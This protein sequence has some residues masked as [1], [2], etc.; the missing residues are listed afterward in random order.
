MRRAIG[1]LLGIVCC[2]WGEAQAAGLELKSE[3][4]RPGTKL[5]VIDFYATWCKPCMAAVPQWKALH[6]KYRAQ[7]LRF[8]VIGAEDRGHCAKPPDWTPDRVICDSAGEWQRQFNVLRLPTSFLYSWDGAVQLRGEDVETIEAGI[9]NF[10]TQHHLA[11]EVD[12][13]NVI[14]DKFAVSTNPDWLKKYITAQLTAQSKF[15][16]VVASEER[17]PRAPVGK[18]CS[19]AFSL[20]PNSVLRITVQ[21]DDRNRRELS[22]AIE[23]NGCVLAAAHEPY[24]G[25]DLTEDLDSMRQAAG[26][27][28]KALLARLVHGEPIAW[29]EAARATE[30]LSP[31]QAKVAGRRAAALRE[32]PETPAASPVKSGRARKGGPVLD[33]A[34][35]SDDDPFWDTP[36][37]K[38]E[39]EAP[40]RRVVQEPVAR[41]REPDT[42]PANDGRYDMLDAMAANRGKSQYEIMAQA[43]SLDEMQQKSLAAQVMSTLGDIRTMQMAFRED[44]MRGQGCYAES[45]EKLH[46]VSPTLAA[47]EPFYRLSIVGDCKSFV[48]RADAKLATLTRFPHIVLSKDGAMSME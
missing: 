22:L 36:T 2:M 31:M 30:D 15:D 16:V 7:G 19:A 34:E 1:L 17:L 33:S 13:I 37:A 9:R 11:L 10:Y 24:K 21:G 42:G 39:P 38:A 48:A 46:Y 25:Q 3:L 20:P 32:E 40:P 27:A 45:L 29:P 4:A 12:E 44:P 35:L 23:K 26:K 14:G 5:L 47:L 18:D 43:S 6:A 41:P 8:V 28:V